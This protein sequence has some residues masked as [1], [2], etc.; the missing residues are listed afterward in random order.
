MQWVYTYI[1]TKLV[2]KSEYFEIIV[3]FLC[4]N[5]RLTILA[6]KEIELPQENPHIKIVIPNKALEELEKVLEDD[7]QEVSVYLISNKVLIVYNDIAFITR[8]IEGN[9][10]DTTGL[11]PKEEL[12]TLKFKKQDLLATVDRASLFTSLDSTNIIK[13]IIKSN[14]MVLK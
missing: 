1:N 3:D 2:P 8:L 6:K 10:P 7:D 12:T 9:Y 13:L 14:K 5:F 4:G 11:F